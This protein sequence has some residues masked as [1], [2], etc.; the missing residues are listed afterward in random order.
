MLRYRGKKVLG[1]RNLYKITLKGATWKG[2]GV[3]KV[4]HHTIREKN[5]ERETWGGGGR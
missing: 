5:L 1:L 2:G 4:E 3:L